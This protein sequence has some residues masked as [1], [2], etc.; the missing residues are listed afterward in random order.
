MNRIHPLKRVLVK[1][2]ALSM[3]PPGLS[4]TSGAA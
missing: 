2:K 4:Q 3:V 1:I